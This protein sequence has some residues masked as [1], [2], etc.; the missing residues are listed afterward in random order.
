MTVHAGLGRRD[1]GEIGSFHTGV[2]IPAV[3]PDISHVM[4]VTEWHRLVVRDACLCCPGR[5]APRAKKP[6]Q[7]SQ[8]KYGSEDT[9]P[10]IR[11][12]AAMKD[13][14][15]MLAHLASMPRTSRKLHFIYALRSRRNAHG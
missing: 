11:I 13:L 5:P 4:R 12:R 7:K 8:Y 6:Q 9:H 3:Q 1:V 2:T 15:H 14:W 10:R